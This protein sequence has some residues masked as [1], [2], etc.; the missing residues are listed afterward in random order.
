MF[1]SKRNYGQEIKKERICNHLAKKI[2][3][4]ELLNEIQT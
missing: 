3:F 4:Y 2:I 1:L